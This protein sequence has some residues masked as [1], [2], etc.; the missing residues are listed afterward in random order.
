MSKRVIVNEMTKVEGHATLVLRI[1]DGRVE[2]CDLRTVEG[3]RYFEGILLH[4]RYDE[5]SE[6]ASRICGICSCA[7]TV[8]A[9]QA[10]ENALGIQPSEQTMDLRVL[11]TLGERI[12][13]HATHLYFF[14]LPDYL[15][16]PSGMSMLLDRRTDVERGLTLMKTG[17]EI[18]RVVGGREMHPVSATVGGFLR[19]P[20]PA[21]LDDLRLRLQRA[22]SAALATAELFNGLTYPSLE[23]HAEHFSIRCDMG[24]AC[25]MG[26]IRSADHEFE[27]SKYDQFITEYH[28][29][30][31]TANF[32]VRQDRAYM[33]GALSRL[34]NNFDQLSAD[35]RR[36]ADAGPILSGLNNPFYNNVAQAIEL[37]HS[38]DQALGILDRLEPNLE[39]LPEIPLHEGRGVAAIEVP[40]GTLWHEYVLDPSGHITHANI[41][42]PT[43]Q[44]LRSMED[45]IR[46]ALPTLLDLK[47]D[48]IVENIEQL[49]RAY[50]PCFSCSAHFLRVTWL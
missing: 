24:Y 12:R 25:L 13:S 50:D 39:P 22:K 35:A 46:I 41:I 36:L 3:S 29:S 28:E 43:A 31:Q 2:Q 6:I 37:V 44:N 1:S 8:C 30:D 14:A 34:A 15:G 48:E 32:V 40:R 49:I 27:Q 26:H 45:D 33:V 18:V 38:V 4:R 19:M 16:Y 23:H 5:A 47:R 42:T 20:S 9:I 17:N 7:H 10:I 21:E 11:L